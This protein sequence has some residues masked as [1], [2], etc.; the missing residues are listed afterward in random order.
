MGNINI[1][2][3]RDG[4][5]GQTADTL[6]QTNQVFKALLA[7]EMANEVRKANTTTG[8][9]TS[10]GLVWYDLQAGAKLLYPVLTPLRNEIPRVM[11]DGGTATNWK[12]I[13]G[14]NVGRV[15][16]GVSE[17]NRN[18]AM[19]TTEQDYLAKYATIGL[20]N[21]VT[22]EGDEAAGK[23][24]DSKSLA[25][26][27]LLQA[28]MI[29]EEGVIIGGNASLAL[30]TTPTPAVAAIG[31]GGTIP[32]ATV[33]SVICAALTYDGYVNGSVSAGIIAS[34]TRTN[35]DSSQD[36]FGGG[37]AQKSAGANVTTAAASSSVSAVVGTPVKGAVAYAWFWG[38]VG[39]E[40][41]G[42]ITT[43]NSVLITTAV[44][45][46][47]QLASSL[48]T[49]DNSTNA[50]LFDGM[51]TQIMKPGSNSYVYSMPNGA[52]GTGTGLTA[53]GAG[54]VTEI[55]NALRSFWDNYRLS[56]EEILVNSQELTNI[57]KKVISNGGAPLFRFNIDGQKGE[58]ADVTVTA[59][60]VVGSYL[61][62][63]ALGG[64][65]LIAIRLHPNIPAGT[66]IF[67]RKSSPYP[68]S[69]VTNIMEIRTRRDYYQVAWPL[70]TRKYEFGVYASEVLAIYFT[71]AF[72][73]ISNIANA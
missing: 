50:L 56:P 60:S 36:T 17:G 27:T 38:T 1:I 41:L 28:M 45:S 7:D 66:I 29:G 62:Q 25:S 71:P 64:G 9:N 55:D 68:I 65:T 31:S 20:E 26:R 4:L 44:G 13:T 63:F 70:R 42:A 12:A 24:D 2:T 67:R 48:P 16:I 43:I 30:G 19:Q 58:S 53:S 8:I 57:T 69:N 35:A 37:V 72:G 18:A 51:I 61:N 6:R 22:F 23:F 47:T 59:G 49:A 10:T 15:S 5:L 32:T 73:I 33:V 21:F 14:I 40:T 34:V 52:A 46:G 39:N 3:N 11:G 54:G